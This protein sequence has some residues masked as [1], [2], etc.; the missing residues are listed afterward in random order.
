[1]QNKILDRDQIVGPYYDGLVYRQWTKKNVSL[2]THVVKLDGSFSEVYNLEVTDLGGGINEYSYAN[3][4]RPI[5]SE[6]NVEQF[7]NKYHGTQII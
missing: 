4:D 3:T 1:M 6:L 7:L 5:V 2:Y